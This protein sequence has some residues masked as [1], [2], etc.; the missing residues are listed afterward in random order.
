MRPTQ[1]LMIPLTLAIGLIVA[2]CSSGGAAS[3]PPADAPTA[4]VM[5]HAVELADS[6]L[7]MIL[8]DTEGR[9]LYGFAPDSDGQPTCYDAC[10]T[11]WPPYLGTDAAVVGDGLDQAALTPVDR[12]D[13]TT[14]LAFGGWPLYH[15]ANDS[16]AGDTNGQGVGDV[17]YV[18]GADGEFIQ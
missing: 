16:A 17:W 6:S 12:T 5:V 8:V 10:A 1:R 14:Q 4:E 13:G 11:N 7:G 9:T 3:A 15:F 18:I 2:A